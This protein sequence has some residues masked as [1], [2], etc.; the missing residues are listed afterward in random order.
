MA[1]DFFGNEI[2]S[3]DVVACLLAKRKFNK[4]SHLRNCIKSIKQNIFSVL[5]LWRMPHFE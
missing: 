5:S 3:G 4:L 1:N 2:K